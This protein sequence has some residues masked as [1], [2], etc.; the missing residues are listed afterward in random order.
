MKIISDNIYESL[1]QYEYCL[2]NDCRYAKTKDG[3]RKKK[4]SI[5]KSIHDNLGGIVTHMR[6]DRRDLGMGEG[7]R[8][9]VYTDPDSKTQWGFA[10]ELFDDGNVIVHKMM[11]M[12]LVKENKDVQESINLMWR[13]LKIKI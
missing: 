11:N 3:A 4:N 2:V 10:Y 6:S 8:K 12:S 9:Y 13:V 1:E 7:Y 5:I